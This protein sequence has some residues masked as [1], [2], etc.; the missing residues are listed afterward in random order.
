[1]GPFDSSVLSPGPGSVVHS[2]DFGV[3]QAAIQN[4]A[5]PVLG[6][7]LGHQGIAHSNGAKIIHADEPIHGRV[8]SVIHYGDPLF[9]GI[10]SPW[11][12]VRYHSL[13]VSL[14][15]PKKLMEIAHTQSG[16]LMGLRH[17]HKPQWGVQFHPESILTQHG[18][19]LM[20]NFRDLSH[21][22]HNR[23]VIPVKVEFDQKPAS[24]MRLLAKEFYTDLSTEDVFVGLFADKENTFWIDS[25]AADPCTSRFSYLGQADN[26]AVEIFNC[27]ED[28]Q[29]RRTTGEEF[30]HRLEQSLAVPI[31]CDEHLPFPFQGGWVGYF[32]YEMKS[33]FGADLKHS[34]DHPDALWLRADRFIAYDHLQDRYWAVSVCVDEQLADSEVWLEW[35][36]QR[37]TE[38]DKAG[39]VK[40]E[41]STGQLDLEMDQTEND[42]VDSIEQCRQAIR[43]GESYQ[44]CLT[45]KLT[46][47][48]RVDGL[49]LYRL[50]RNSNPAPFACYVSG[51]GVEVVSS[52]PERFLQV[53]Q[54]GKVETKPIKG[55]ARRDANPK[56]DKQ[57]A[58]QLLASEK[59]RAENLMIV[60][61]LRNDL[62]RVAKVDSVKVPSLIQLES[63]ATVH[64]LVSTVTAQLRDDVGLIDLIKATFPGGSITGAP[65]LRS[66]Q[67]L[68][69]L[70]LSARGPYCG[71]IGYLGYNRIMDLNIA[72]RTMLVDQTTVQFG[73]GGGITY[74]SDKKTE[75]EEILLK[76][77][78]L[79]DALCAY[80]GAAGQSSTKVN[81]R[82]RG[83]VKTSST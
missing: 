34:S 60:D 3:S 26:E 27:S 44:I 39:E 30:L 67:I 43:D 18:H 53:E 9:E 57:L 16:A 36:C 70:E 31:A 19:R 13:T 22:H 40:L 23:A 37:I 56:F 79:I 73:V 65:K 47:H 21:Q 4:A 11:E 52:S 48:G 58:Q 78:A 46:Y 5:V 64:Q 38:L 69:Q 29:Q 59:D 77:D 25:A 54:S 62:S 35:L 1:M 82:K 72:I 81:W 10:P 63:Y 51:G 49:A 2:K 14:P 42:Y 66:M 20:R 33:L 71:S 76:A 83:S 68:D 75:Y 32:G 17:K 8:S 24:V 50:L 7:C 6:V 45:N 15:L 41:K 28:E 61:L 55:T 80:F 74:L 12:V